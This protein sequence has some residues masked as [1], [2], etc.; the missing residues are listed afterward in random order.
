MLDKSGAAVQT[1]FSDIAGTYD[2]LNHL[3]SG[4]QDRRWRRR[5]VAQLCPRRGE[6]VLDLCCGTGD[7]TRQLQRHQPR[8]SVVGADFALPMLELARQKELPALVAAD[9]LRLPF[10]DASFDAVSVAFGARNFEDTRLGLAEIHRVLKPEG[11]I[12]VLEF[13]R[14]TSPLLQQAF[15]AFN[16]VL[17]PLGRVVSH[18]G[19]AYNY[20]PQSIG[21]FFTRAEFEDLLREAGFGRVRSFDFSLGIATSFLGRKTEN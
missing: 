2:L 14:P 21:G 16:W 19:S 20:L 10:P 12:L 15:G 13:M 18:H 9:A 8:A 11:R 17:A 7:L 1:M 6:L 4:N 5:A 3:L